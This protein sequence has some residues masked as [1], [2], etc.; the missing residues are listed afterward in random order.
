M[1]EKEKPASQEILEQGDSAPARR[2]LPEEMK[3]FCWPKG[4]SGNPNGRPKGAK[5]RET[6]IRQVL[7]SNIHALPERERNHLVALL[8]PAAYDMTL[9]EIMVMQLTRRAIVKSDTQAFK[10][11]FENLYGRPTANVNLNQK[12]HE[13]VLNEVFGGALT[14]DK[15]DGGDE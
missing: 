4:K 1:E 11:I 9:A 2:V 15:K 3:P 8:G 5:N 14:G 7:E 13:D 12:T 6:I 10:A